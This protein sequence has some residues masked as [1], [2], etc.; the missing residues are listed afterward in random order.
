MS[1]SYDSLEEV[2]GRA[3]YRLP[4]KALG[5]LITKAEDVILNNSDSRGLE[6]EIQKMLGETSVFSLKKIEEKP[7]AYR[8]AAAA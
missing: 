6:L 1:Y 3:A 2:L 8:R 5:V 4:V 7:S